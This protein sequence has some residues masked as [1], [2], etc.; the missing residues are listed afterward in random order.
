VPHLLWNLWLR[1]L[2]SAGPRPAAARRP[3]YRP[4]LEVL[5]DRLPPGDVA[6]GSTL[7]GLL[8]PADPGTSAL[9]SSSDVQSPGSPGSTTT[10]GGSGL[11]AGAPGSAPGSVPDPGNPTGPVA[12]SDPSGAPDPGGTP[13][14][15]G[16]T[17]APT[18]LTPPGGGSSAVLPG[19]I[20]FTG[21]G[22]FSSPIAAP[23]G[24]RPVVPPGRHGAHGRPHRPTHPRHTPAPAVH[25]GPKHRHDAGSLPVSGTTL[26]APTPSPV[27]PP[28][29]TS[30]PAPTTDASPG[31]G[32]T[33]TWTQPVTCPAANQ[34]TIA[35]SGSAF[36]GGSAPGSSGPGSGGGA[37]SHSGSGGGASG[38]NGDGG[39]NG[40][41]TGKQLFPV[42]PPTVGPVTNATAGQAGSQ[43][44]VAISA[45]PAHP[46]HLFLEANDQDTTAG[47]TG[48]YIAQSS[49]NGLTWFNGQEIGT[50]KGADTFPV[51]AGD[52][53]V[54][55]DQYGNLFMTYIDKNTGNAGG[56]DVF[57]STD[58]GTT[59][60]LLTTIAGTKP[61]GGIDQPTVVTGPSAD[62]HGSVW[63]DF[64]DF[65]G[66][67]LMVASGAEVRG[68]GKVGAF[69]TL[70][71]APG[72]DNGNFGDISIGP[73]GEVMIAYQH[74]FATPGPDVI[75]V[76]VKRDG[77]GPGPFSAPVVVTTTNV[78]GFA[79]VLAQPNRSI[80]A[81][82]GLAWDHSGGIHN[83]RA[84]LMY[85]DAPSVAVNNTQTNIFVRTS[86]DGGQS[87]SSPVMVND[88]T[89]SL[90][91]LPRIAL[92]QT[93]GFVG[94][95][96]YDTRNDPTNTM[97]EFFMSFSTNGGR[98]FLPNVQ[99]ES[100]PSDVLPDK[101]AGFDYG[102][103]TGATYDHGVYH[104]AW[105]DNSASFG[106]NPDSDMDIVSVAVKPGTYNA[107]ED[108]FEPNDTSDK[109]ILMG[110]LT[111][112]ASASAPNLTI[113][114]HANNFPDYDWF[115]WNPTASGTV[116]VNMAVGASD[117]DLELHV[118][119]L[120]KNNT[121][122]ELGNTTSAMENADNA[123]VSL[124][125]AVK[126]GDPL[127]VEVKGYEAMFGR[128]GTGFYDLNV[129]L[130]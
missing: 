88:A 100:Q 47:L 17:P 123:S 102:D 25:H 33:R 28:T 110:P 122:V 82:A 111:A 68:L 24:A 124:Q 52:P 48:V 4:L 27:A 50:G 49:D 86:D 29:A 126:A 63:V 121:L 64:N 93:S 103:Y 125:V 41:T 89:G 5:E 10:L 3:A 69:S 79:P 58:E 57:L 20:P 36:G 56:V 34:E 16:S 39:S 37:S 117:G 51:T 55:F 44:E 99:L 66:T 65:G 76:N 13:P 22:A 108:S 11:G 15:G 91:F 23:G 7:S 128:W 130:S 95:S 104:P 84:Y 9:P 85:T 6:G 30:P 98:T 106:G 105:A 59:F 31:D 1:P 87:W 2:R 116:T 72:S 40:S 32:C 83:G 54:A 26:A 96:F 75:Q 78:G 35:S 120:D 45:D 53:S 38:S 113:A 18:P 61:S 115:R 97:P 94:V 112:G 77:L 114:R 62:G 101:N 46:G 80:D 14:G 71:S 107:P 90:H 19:V 8:L 73:G 119:T 118:F 42:T 21:S 127:L 81:E 12:G 60:T 129:S 43:A 109:A 67:G 92:D 70:F 74:D